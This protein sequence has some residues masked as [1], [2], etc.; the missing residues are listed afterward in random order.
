MSPR[1]RLVPVVLAAALSLLPAGAR[2]QR[3]EGVEPFEVTDLNVTFGPAE[4][5]L[6]ERPDYV[7][8]YAPYFRAHATVRSRGPLPEGTTI[9]WVQQVDGMTI[10]VDYAR[11][12]LTWELPRVP[13]NDSS[14]RDFPWYHLLHE[15]REVPAQ[16]ES[17]VEVSLDDAPAGQ[18]TW[19]EPLPPRGQ[20]HG[21]ERELRAF[22]REQRFTT[23]LAV[24]RAPERR[25]TVLRK[26]E[27]GFD[28]E[29]EADPSRPLGR[30]CRVKSV[31][32]REPVITDPAQSPEPLRIPPHCLAA[33]TAN[34]SQQLWWNP[35]EPGSGVRARLQ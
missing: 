2:G 32:L 23:W 21:A 35:R 5:T 26:I 33:P 3:P 15:R 19:R 20:E 16:P 25:M 18:V 4:L 11:A 28:F 9:G 34:Q 6:I 31:R 17:T 27:W 13:V 24:R 29:V 1:L 14:G 30:R 7:R 10:H 8:Y 12:F 22:R